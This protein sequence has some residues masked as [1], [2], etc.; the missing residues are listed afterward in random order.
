MLKGSKGG[1]EVKIVFVCTGNTCRSPMAKYLL[2]DLIA[3]NH[4]SGIEVLSAGVS[5]YESS[6]ISRHA[7]TLLEEK[8]I[9]ASS[10]YSVLLTKKL[11]D[12]ASL[13][14]TMGQSHKMAILNKYPSLS[15]KVYV[16]TEYVGENGDIQDPYGGSLETYRACMNEIED[17]ITKLYLQI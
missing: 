16:L 7:K 12:E 5:V 1:V 15:E 17:L 13:I 3:K 4:K 14:L 6:P 10:H 8:R 11:A 9:D 2:K